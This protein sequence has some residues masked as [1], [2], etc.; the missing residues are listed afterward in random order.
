MLLDGSWE[1]SDTISGEAPPARYMHRVPVPG[2]VHSPTP[3]F[4]DVDEFQSKA[5]QVV[6]EVRDLDLS[7]RPWTNGYWAVPHDRL[8]IHARACA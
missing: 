5:L 2:L 7:A 6:P 8:G 1:I 4:R 3:A